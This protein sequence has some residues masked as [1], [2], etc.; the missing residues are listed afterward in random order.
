MKRYLLVLVLCVTLSACGQT[1]APTPYPTY[2]PVP[3]LPTYTPLPTYTSLP[4]PLPTATTKPTA[5]PIPTATLVPT[6][7]STPKPKVGTR[8]SPI[9]LGNTATLEIGDGVY[10]GHVKQAVTGQDAVRMITSANMFNEVPADGFKATLIYFVAEYTKGPEDEEGGL[11][12]WYFDFLCG[13][14]KF[15]QDPA[16]VEPSPAFGGS[17]FPG[18]TFEGWLCWFS[19]VTDKPDLLLWKTSPFGDREGVYFALK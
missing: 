13:D 7:T 9:P 15:Y 5:T 18:A 8:G 17:G 3:S 12:D 6:L 2:T 14:G 10:V 19:K 1:A 4:T 11:S 16:V